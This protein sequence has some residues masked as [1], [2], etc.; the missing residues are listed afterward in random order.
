VNLKTE[1]VL[2]Y[3]ENSGNM[4]NDVRLAFTS[5]LLQSDKFD[6][7]AVENFKVLAD[8]IEE[9]REYFYMRIV[10]KLLNLE[11]PQEALHYLRKLKKIRYQKDAVRDFVDY[12]WDKNRI[13]FADSL[14]SLTSIEQDTKIFL[15]A[16]KAITKLDTLKAR[17]LAKELVKI[18]P[19]SPYAIKLVPLLDDT[20]KA[21]VYFSSKNYKQAD[22]I[23]AKINTTC[24]P[25][26]QILSAYR[27][28]N[29]EKTIK[30]FEK[31]KRRLTEREEKD[32]FLPIGYAYWKIKKPLKGLEYLIFLANDG[33]ESA[34]RLVTDI[35]ITENS[36][37]LEQYRKNVVVRS[38]I[39]AY[40]L[41]L[42]HLFIKDTVGAESLLIKS[43][44]G[45]NPRISVR[46]K[47]F[48]KTLG[49]F[50][51]EQKNCELNLDYFY[52]LD[53]G[54]VVK[55]EP[56]PEVHQETIEKLRIFKY[57]LILGDQTE[58]LNYLPNE[59]NLIYG[60]IKLAEH[61]GNDYIRIRLALRYYNYLPEKNSIPLY[62]LKH[63]FPTNYYGQIA[64][65][66]KFYNVKPEVVIALM[67]EE[68]LFNPHAISPAGA[69]GL[70]QI[71]PLTGKKIMQ[72][73]TPDSLKIPN[74]NITI[75]IKYLSMLSDSF[76]NLIHV[77][78]GY[79]AG[80]RRIR[81]WEKTYK[82]DDPLLF[83]ELI[84]FKETREYV[85][86]IL[87]SIIIYQYLLRR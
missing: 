27:L 33:N 29:Y 53:E 6:S 11:K 34:A 22:S 50:P 18:K 3:L 19:F 2:K 49:K 68:S 80:E 35:L 28:R 36:E 14:L 1:K 15:N 44:V 87:R 81:E 8:S 72:E 21:Y 20:L 66:A 55:S 25:F 63:L 38:Q 4:S 67:R 86:R 7:L 51:E 40:S 64:T 60:A 52:L 79:N 84:P 17:S 13:E 62:L 75:G 85:Q 47:Y 59:P 37:I 56:E 39:M 5:N 77:L 42:Y 76:Q 69:I 61:Y 45:N 58:A 41:A 70:M 30:L 71:M 23:F 65:V 78:C 73:A 12:I 16:L 48:L 24:Y 9:L 57:L 74:L 83:T 82:T 54:L 31:L 46:A 26:A 10:E 43:V 32:L